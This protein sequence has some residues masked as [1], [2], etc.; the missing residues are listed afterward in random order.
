MANNVVF[1]SYTTK[2]VFIVL[3][4]CFTS[5]HKVI[6]V[7]SH[8]YESCFP[9]VL[10]FLYLLFPNLIRDNSYCEFSLELG[11]FVM[12][13]FDSYLHQIQHDLLFYPFRDLP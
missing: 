4:H 1:A 7:S 9:L 13:L 12:V 2:V 11:M 3:I 5:I 10:C 8:E 6:P